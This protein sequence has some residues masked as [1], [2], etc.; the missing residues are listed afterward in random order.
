GAARLAHHP[1]RDA[2][3]GDVVRHRLDDHGASGNTRAVADLDIAEDLGAGADH[4]AAAYLGVTVLVLLTGATERDVMQDRD[5][6]VDLRGLADDEAG[7]VVEEDAAAD[8]R[9][10]VD[11][12]LE[13]G[14]GAA[15]EMKREILAALAE[16]PV[17]QAVRL[18]GVEAL[19]IQKRLAEARRRRIAVDRGDD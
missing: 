6:I 10:R 8:A 4:D 2:G 12:A 14:R 11:V 9:R 13:D 18:D 5:V 1:G 7:R 15:L 17:R 16:Q 3:H 19:V